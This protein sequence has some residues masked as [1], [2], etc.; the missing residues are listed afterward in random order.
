[1]TNAE[2]EITLYAKIGHVD[3]LTKSDAIETHLQ[4]EMRL[5]A[6]SKIR[7]RSTTNGDTETLVFTI[8]ESADKVSGF[9]STKESNLPINK[10]TFDEFV[11]KSTNVFKKT[12]YTFKSDKS[13]AK[14]KDG[15]VIELPGL[16]YEVDVFENSAGRIS[17]WCKIDIELDDALAYID[18]LNVRSMSPSIV[19]NISTLPFNPQNI[20]D[21]RNANSDQLSFID[22]LYANEFKY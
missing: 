13:N 12:R 8:K 10:N 5:G 21:K 19:F 18:T 16:V 4:A 20:I 2:T 15:T 7:V 17:D 14:L 11:N 9:K 1:M 22:Q 6:T 3:G